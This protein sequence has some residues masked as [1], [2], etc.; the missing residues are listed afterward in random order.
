MRPVTKSR[1]HIAFLV[2]NYLPKV[3]GVERH[4]GALAAELV[5]HGHRVTVVALDDEAGDV[6]ENGVRVIRLR[7]WLRV[8][9]VFS[10]PVPGATRRIS[11]LLA[12]EGITVVSTHTR[13]FPMSFVGIRV[14]RRVAA[15]VVHTEHGSG[16][17]QGVSALVGAA[18]RLV[19]R[20]MGRWV[21]RRAT[22]VLGVSE[23]VVAFVERLAKVRAQVF[24]NA[25]DLAPWRAAARHR[26][27]RFVF[28]G[29]LVEGKGWE[30]LLEAVR[31]L[32]A[33]GGA[34]EC[35]VELFGDGP[36]RDRLEAAIAADPVLARSVHARGHAQPPVLAESLARGILVNPTTLSEGFQTSLI[37]ALA[38]GSQIVSYDVP[39]VRM[40]LDDGAP[41]RIIDDRTPAG[42]ALAMRRAFED[43]LTPYRA[44]R[45]ERWGWPRRAEE[46]LEIIGTA[47]SDVPPV[48]TTRPHAID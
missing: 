30:V 33:E 9:D 25:I 18:S 1:H 6:T 2:N 8:G 27:D 11:S 10:L 20:T 17:V 31:L 34:P 19:D 14:A 38:A 47:R 23:G 32:R 46:Y 7:R 16:F 26:P 37:E 22:I 42:L 48:G 24:Y 3:G 44:D 21:L 39:G 40:L 41:I 28:I 15:P 4:V 5:H 29:R 36:Q 43:P 12:A 45:L 13:F 35:S